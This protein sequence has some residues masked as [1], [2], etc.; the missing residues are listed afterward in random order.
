MIDDGLNKL[1]VQF[2]AM[3]DAEVEI[4]K[5]YAELAEKLR[6]TLQMLVDAQQPDSG[7]VV[8]LK[9]SETQIDAKEEP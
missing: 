2:Q 9:P 5:A 6:I 8:P 1:L 4:E 7:T 3:A